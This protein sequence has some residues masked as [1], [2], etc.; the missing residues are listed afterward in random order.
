MYSSVQYCQDQDGI[1]SID[2]LYVTNTNAEWLTCKTC[3]IMMTW[4]DGATNEDIPINHLPGM[5][6]K[7]WNPF[8]VETNGEHIGIYKLKLKWC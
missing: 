7:T 6:R 4:K 8:D 5:T 1:L 2:D 3:G